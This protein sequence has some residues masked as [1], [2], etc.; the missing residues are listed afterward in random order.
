MDAVSLWRCRTFSRTRI[1]RLSVYAGETMERGAPPQTMQEQTTQISASKRLVALQSV[2]AA[3]GIT[4]LKLVTGVLTGSLGMLSEAAHSGVDLIAAAI[5][6]FSIRLSDKPADEDHT[7]GHG[8][9]ESL[10]AFVET[11]LMVVSCIWIVTEAVRRLMGITHVALRI[12]V[13]PVLVLLLSILVDWTRSRQ[14]GK[15]ARASHSLALEADALH[16]S[17]DIWSSVAVLLG[18]GASFAGEHWHIR[19]LEY[20][21]PVA[22]LL[23]SLIILQVSW[24][25]ARQTIDTLLDRTTPEMRSKVVRAIAEVEGVVQVDRV[26]MRQS[27]AKYFADVTVGIARNQTFLRSE[28]MVEAVTAAVRA[29]V[30]EMD[31][32]VHTVPVATKEENVFDRIRAVAQRSGLAIHEVTVQEFEQGLHVEQHLEMPEATT[33][34]DAHEVVTRIEA[35]MR[36]EVPEITT[37]TTHIESEEGTVEKPEPLADAALEEDLRVAAHAFPEVMDVHDVVTRRLGDRLQMACHCTMADAM[38]MGEVHRVISELEAAFRRQR[39]EVTR[40]LIHPEPA[41]DNCR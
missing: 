11:V 40:L 17:T 15:V 29:V 6:L 35:E 1:Q 28:Q 12:S 32:V 20:A 19:A 13:W 24:R 34:H 21:D 31:V 36:R 27:G 7:Y 5:T 10:S 39:P 8:K 2:L 4:L 41:T 25:M 3:A 9:V 14:L 33:L 37:I 16:F 26:R 22:A 18:L 30:P 23:V 38:T